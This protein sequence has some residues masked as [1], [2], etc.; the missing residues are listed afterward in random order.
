VPVTKLPY[1]ARNQAVGI[2]VVAPVKPGVVR[3][4]VVT[5]ALTLVLASTFG[6]SGAGPARPPTTATEALGEVLASIDAPCPGFEA[7]M[8]SGPALRDELF[9]EAAILDLPTAWAQQ[10]SLSNLRELS[11]APQVQL[12]ATPH[13]VGSV[14]QRTEM[15]V[16]LSGASNEQVSLVRW[17]VLP[18]HAEDSTVLELE[19]ELAPPAAKGATALPRT[20]RFSM[21]ARE[22][23]PVLAR[24]SW[25]EATRRSLLLLVRTFAIQSE[26]DLRAI[27]ECKMRQRVQARSRAKA[28]AP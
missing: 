17:S 16:G 26:D 11:R 12:L 20:V 5:L 10:A 24:V 13:L 28:P 19:L 1:R 22:N 18:R 2:G 7:E 9:V 4:R 25:D 27:F 23:E 15:T 14:G 21:T 3:V 6:C 8:S